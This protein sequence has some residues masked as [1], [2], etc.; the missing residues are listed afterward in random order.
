M[1]E[2]RVGVDIPYLGHPSEVREYAQQ[3]EA[4]GFHH[5]GFSAHL[6]STTDTVFPGPMFSF[7]EP[8]RET[9]TLAAFVAA[10]TTRVEINTAMLLLPLYEPVL[11]AKQA[12]EVDNLSEGRLR[13]G[14]SISWNRRECDAV[15]VDPSTRGA[16]LINPCS[17]IPRSTRCEALKLTWVILT[18]QLFVRWRTYHAFALRFQ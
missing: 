9:F 5:L 4:L 15:G 8:W 12:A 11:A 18:G 6:C 2:L 1:T 14:A 3:M 13:I 16:R 17:R 10:V 7:D